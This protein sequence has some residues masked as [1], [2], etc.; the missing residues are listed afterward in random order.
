MWVMFN[1]HFTFPIIEGVA[2]HHYEEKGGDNCEESAEG[3][4]KGWGGGEMKMR[5]E[6]LN[7]CGGVCVCVRVGRGA[8]KSEEKGVKNKEDNKEEGLHPNVFAAQHVLR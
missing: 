6:G 3:G 7:E 8:K 2:W 4:E 5:H 1:V